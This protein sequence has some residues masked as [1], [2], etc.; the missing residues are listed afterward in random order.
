LHNWRGRAAFFSTHTS[1]LVQ[2]H[3]E[4]NIRAGEKNGR[5]RGKKT[6]F[7]RSAKENSSPIESQFFQCLQFHP[8]KDNGPTLKSSKSQDENAYIESTYL[9]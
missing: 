2:G 1:F 3:K 9:S 7:D 5:K 6:L 4:K 8:A